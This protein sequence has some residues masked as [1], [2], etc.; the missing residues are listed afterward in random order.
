MTINNFPNISEIMVNAKN[1]HPKYFSRNCGFP[2]KIKKHYSFV[3][4]KERDDNGEEVTHNRVFFD[5]KHYIG[6]WFI[7]SETLIVDLFYG[8]EHRI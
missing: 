2:K 5:D 8:E 3:E 7:I 6:S 4:D 1:S